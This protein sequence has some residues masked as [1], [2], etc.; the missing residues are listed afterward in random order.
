MADSSL[1]QS[2]LKILAVTSRKTSPGSASIWDL[3]LTVEQSEMSLK[4]VRERTNNIARLGRYIVNQSDPA[5]DVEKT[6]NAAI[7][8]LVAQL[9][10]NFR[11]VWA[12]TV[13]TLTSL[14]PQHA[15]QIWTVVWDQLSKTIVADKAVIPDLEVSNPEWTTQKAAAEE[16]DGYD[17]EDQEFRCTALFKG[18]ASVSRSWAEN[19]DTT[20][21]DVAEISVSS[22]APLRS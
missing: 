14:A 18:R 13:S 8:Y 15:E 2:S 6:I 11:P 16:A 9:K 4:N 19:N 12:E 3:C 17:D 22:T 20:K 5:E 7:T 1:R 21:L 10:V